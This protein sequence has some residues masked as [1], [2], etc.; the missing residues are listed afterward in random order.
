MTLKTVA[1][2]RDPV[3][4]YI[5][6]TGVE[7]AVIDSPFVQRLRRIHQLA[8]AY[9]VYPGAVHTRF[10]HVLGA[11]HVAGLMA[12]SIANN[13]HLDKTKIQ[14]I[15]L[16]ALLHDVGHGPF[17]HLFEEV[18]A[19]KTNLTHE[20]ISQKIVLKS[21]VRDILENYGISSRKISDLCVGKLNKPPYM[22]EIVAGGLS[23]DIMDYLL[24]DS[25]FT[26]VEYGKVDIHRIID[27]IEIVKNHLALNQAALYAF[28]AILI[29]RYEMFKAVY[30]HRT[31]RAS[32][33]ML[34]HS[35]SLANNALKLTDF[36]RIENYLR[37]TDEIVFDRL[38][39]LNANTPELRIARRLAQDHNSRRL[40]KCVFEKVMQRKDRTVERIFDQSR[41]RQEL[42]RDIARKA[43]VNEADVYVDVPT[44]PSVPYTY[45]REAPSSLILVQED[46]TGKT[47]KTVPINELQLVGSITGFM[48]ILRVYTQEENRKK[49]AGAVHELFGSNGFMARISV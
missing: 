32:E 42:A 15:R 2:I 44:T 6:I 17:S 33:L 1:E 10:D 24:R 3:H 29:A 45:T 19:E 38:M 43:A 46:A 25:Y 41:F 47:H 23:A 49:V 27:S 31:V 34:V 20:D 30:F 7:R 37:L 14:D 18:L 13:I 9:M 28:E 22:N 39:N 21:N 11:M 35:M 48:D 26:G 5:K 8:G 16:A 12:E 4:G 40:V 36:S